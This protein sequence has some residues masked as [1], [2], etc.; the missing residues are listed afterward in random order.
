MDTVTPAAGSEAGKS[1]VVKA[2]RT[3]PLLTG[4]IFISLSSAFWKAVAATAHTSISQ[5]FGY[6]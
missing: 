1:R 2:H 3:E 4:K 5:S 6:G